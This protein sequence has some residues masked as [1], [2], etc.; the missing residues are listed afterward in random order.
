MIQWDTRKLW[1]RK[2]TVKQS[3]LVF[4]FGN[5][6]QL[7]KWNGCVN[8]VKL[9]YYMFIGQLL[10]ITWVSYSIVWIYIKFFLFWFLATLILVLPKIFISSE[11][12]LVVF[13]KSI[14]VQAT[15]V[16]S[17]LMIWQKKSLIIQDS[18]WR[19]FKYKQVDIRHHTPASADKTENSRISCK[20]VFK[21]SAFS[22]E[23]VEVFSVGTAYLNLTFLIYAAEGN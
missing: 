6:N 23:F 12:I 22:V 19:G 16:G 18:R 10:F 8:N 11:S 20:I 5:L 1:K 4:D 2:T 15:F 9:L 13:F 17:V 7:F 14:F 21:F 3:E